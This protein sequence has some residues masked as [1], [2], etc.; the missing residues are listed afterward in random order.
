MKMSTKL[1]GEPLWRLAVLRPQPV[2]WNGADE[3]TLGARGGIA[4]AVVLY[5]VMT[6]SGGIERAEL[7]QIFQG[8]A[9]GGPDRSHLRRILHDL[10]K[11]FGSEAIT[12]EERVQ[13]QLPVSVDAEELLALTPETMPDD[14][15]SIYQGDFLS[16][17]DK[18]KHAGR[19]WSW[20]KERRGECRRHAFALLDR[21][22]SATAELGEWERVRT[23]GRRIAALWPG[24]EEGYR[25]ELEAL[26]QL[27]LFTDARERYADAER[28]LQ[29]TALSPSLIEL[30]R[31]LRQQRDTRH[32]SP[33]PSMLQENTGTTSTGATVDGKGT[34]AEHSEPPTLRANPMEVGSGDEVEATRGESPPGIGATSG[35]S[36]EPMIGA[37]AEALHESARAAD[38]PR[39]RPGDHSPGQ[40]GWAASAADPRIRPRIS[41]TAG[42][43]RRRWIAL[44]ALMAVLV[45]AVVAFPWHRMTEAGDS[46]RRGAGGK[47]PVC[48]DGTG[49]AAL[50]REVYHRGWGIDAGS[51]F[52]KAWY[53][54]NDGRCRWADGFKVVRQ[55]PT[56]SAETRFIVAADTLRL[57]KEVL[58]GDSVVIR[59]RMWAPDAHAVVRDRW[60]LLDASAGTVN[61]DGSPYL[62]VELIVRK[63]PVALCRP[64][65]LVAELVAR[66]HAERR[67]MAA[68][69]EFAASWTLIN[70]RL[71]AWPSGTR[72]HRRGSGL[73]S[74]SGAT[75]SVGIT[76]GVLPGETVT[77][78][79]P[80]RAPTHTGTY[81]EEWELAANDGTTRPIAG[82]R[83]VWVRIESVSPGEAAHLRAER[84]GTGEVIAGFVSET[85]RD[86]T[87]LPPDRVFEKT[88]TI[89]NPG[90]CRWE[91]PMKLQFKRSTGPRLSLVDEVLVEGS[92]LPLEPYSF[93]VRMRTPLQPGT[94][95]E[96]WELMGPG[97]EVVAIPN[98]DEVW[99][100]IVVPVGASR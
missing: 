72:L 17:W 89:R 20:V 39:L 54:K 13:W 19:F 85:V 98:N 18:L 30:G 52:T 28:T 65:E 68:G 100:T 24:R 44:G 45:V 94:Y 73:G 81:E 23:I 33:E 10:R 71:C 60:S 22:A 88:W 86:F 47:I 15:L 82:G 8:M 58:P 87:E 38:R 77:L 9:G 79:I 12:G 16:G 11:T 84:C 35:A 61:V 93:T 55:S 91:A 80:M 27:E 97:E 76:D 5:L 42:P 7:I 2:I 69:S 99:V 21:R 49:R 78:R 29:D 34:A 96:Y 75:R 83:S 90:T 64:N 51:E 25:W 41:S 6:R 40:S 95:S 63:S 43:R 48:R 74:L 66:S 46:G 4:L 37:K 50:V 92:V 31:R 62:P 70:P 67:I 26:E 59:I 1:N 32:R 57:G 14:T 56:M 36:V 3:I 53:L